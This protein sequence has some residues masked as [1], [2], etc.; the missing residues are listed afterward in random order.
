[1]NADL[2]RVIGLQRLDTAADAARKKLADEP[3]REKALDARLEAARQSVAS[4][5]ARRSTLESTTYFTL[6][7]GRAEKLRKRFGPQ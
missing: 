4:T 6:H 1:M 2:E 3:E 7:P 5:K